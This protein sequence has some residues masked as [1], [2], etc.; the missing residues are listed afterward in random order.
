[1]KTLSLAGEMFMA[2]LVP[3]AANPLPSAVCRKMTSRDLFA[4]GNELQIEHRGEIYTLRLTS[5]GKLI[6]T[7]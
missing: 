6:L 1:M 4:S 5:K 7:K 3:D 2:P